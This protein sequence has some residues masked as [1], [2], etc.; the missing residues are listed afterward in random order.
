[1][2]FSFSTSK[3]PELKETDSLDTDA[4]EVG[5]T[6]EDFFKFMLIEKDEPQQPPPGSF[7]NKTE[8]E[9]EEDDDDEEEE[10]VK[11]EFTKKDYQK[12]SVFIVDFLNRII[13]F[14][15]AL[16]TGKSSLM[17][18]ADP[19]DY[20][21]LKNATYDY[22]ESLKIQLTPGQRFSFVFV[23][24]YSEAFVDVAVKG[25]KWTYNIIVKWTGKPSWKKDNN[26]SEENFFSN[27]GAEEY[28][29]EEV[30]EDTIIMEPC[31][32]C[33]ALFDKRKLRK[34]HI[35]AL[36]EDKFFCNQS[37]Y[38]IFMNENNFIGRQKNAKS[39]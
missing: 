13:P 32:Q 31:A 16:I 17:Y 33:G 7:Y 25:F 18:K 35:K 34:F 26:K 30:N 12:T 4:P 15:A 39:N 24:V 37:H 27:F 38:N 1:M 36:G 19:D 6:K 29:M 28:T 5:A 14:S 9:E 8:V 20:D 22:V 21:R 23:E 10:P 2:S 11:K 3:R